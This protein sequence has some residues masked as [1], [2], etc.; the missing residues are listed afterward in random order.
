MKGKKIRRKGKLRLSSYFKKIEDGKK[1]SVVRELGIK[2]GFP[3]RIIGKS[4]KVVGVR[5]KC[6]LVE[7][8]DGNK[9][10]TFIIHPVH[11]KLLK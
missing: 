7:L 10:K 8:K 3:K 5:G 9:T 2:A 1:V 4:G 6:K 11:L